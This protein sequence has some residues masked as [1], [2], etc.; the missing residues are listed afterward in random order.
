MAFCVLVIAEAA[1]LTL[2]LAVRQIVD[3]VFFVNQQMAIVVIMAGC[4]AARYYLVMDGR[5]VSLHCSSNPS[6][7]TI[8][9]YLL[10]IPV[11]SHI[12]V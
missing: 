3:Q 1:A 4:S 2:P 5:V 10:P 9:V 6:L 11:E 12:R 7:N 8:L